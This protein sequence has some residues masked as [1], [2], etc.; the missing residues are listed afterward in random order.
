MMPAAVESQEAEK[1]HGNKSVYNTWA[2]ELH[3]IDTF[4][5]ISCAL[6]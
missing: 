1:G 6:L 3:K 4:H 2:Y 5:F